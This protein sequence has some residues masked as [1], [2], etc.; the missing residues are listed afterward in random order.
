MPD[1]FFDNIDAGRAI[2]WG[3]TSRDYD[4]YRPGPPDSF[5]R[6]LLALNIGLPGHRLLDLGT[7]TG[8]LAR[9]FAAGKVEVSG[10]DIS[11]SQIAMASAAA[12]REGL[13]I[14]FNVSVAE[15][16]PYPD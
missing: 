12:V 7:G 14:D 10:V 4:R 3:K 8:L 15:D 5:Y 13:V 1:Q 16:L 2:D 6:K 11:D 9:R